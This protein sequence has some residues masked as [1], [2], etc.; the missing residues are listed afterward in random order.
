[1]GEPTRVGN[2]H[3]TVKVTDANNQIATQRISVVLR[4]D[5]NAVLLGG[6]S[7][8]GWGWAAKSA[9]ATAAGRRVLCVFQNFRDAG[10]ERLG[11]LAGQ[12]ELRGELL[13]LQCPVLFA[14]LAHLLHCALQFRQELC[15]LRL[16]LLGR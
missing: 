9:T 10:G 11:F 12:S 2:Y 6:C 7:Y 14:Q 1:M 8:R 13:V 4:L 3:F 15:D 16:L 5:H